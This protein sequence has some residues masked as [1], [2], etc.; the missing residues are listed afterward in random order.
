MFGKGLVK[1]DAALAHHALEC[2]A[3]FQ[4]LREALARLVDISGSK[5]QEQVAILRHGGGCFMNSGNLGHMGC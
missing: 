2:V 5:A 3:H 1:F 4:V